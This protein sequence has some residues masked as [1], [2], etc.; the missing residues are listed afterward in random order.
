MT[1]S[2]RSKAPDEPV[3]RHLSVLLPFPSAKLGA[4]SRTHYLHKGRIAKASRRVAHLC[5][6]AAMVGLP[7]D[8]FPLRRYLVA[9]EFLLPSRHRRDLDNLVGQMKP[10]LDGLVDCGL[11]A[12]DSEAVRLTA[13]KRLV[14]RADAGVLATFIADADLIDAAGSPKG[15]V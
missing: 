5:G 9:Y 2:R 11:L 14:G 15:S 7:R 1:T 8:S 4:N 13:T 12:D 3:V 10:F 6:I